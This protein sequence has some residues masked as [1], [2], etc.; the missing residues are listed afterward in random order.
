MYGSSLFWKVICLSHVKNFLNNTM[1]SHYKICT[2]R[3][4]SVVISCWQ[5]NV[6]FF[7]IKHIKHMGK[8]VSAAHCVTLIRQL[9]DLSR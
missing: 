5:E 1:F 8:D 6:I 9:A 2:I 7:I 4:D 3:I